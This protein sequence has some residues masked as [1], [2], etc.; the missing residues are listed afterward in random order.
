MAKNS[1]TFSVAVKLLTDQFSKGIK[2]IERQIKGLGGFIRGAFALGSITAFGKQM[3]QVSSEF[4]DAMARVH[5]VSDAIDSDFKIMEQEARRLGATTKFTATEAANALE[6]LTRNGLTAQQATNALEGTLQLAQANAI[7]LAEAATITTNVLNMFGMST[8]ETTR[9]NNVLSQVSATTAT[10]ISQLYEALVNAA[11]TAHNL[12]LSLEEVS[13]ALGAM[14]QRGV[15]GAEAGTQLRMAMTKMVDPKIVKKMNEMGIAINEEQ[16]RSEGL[17]KTIGRL[18]DAHLS[19]GQLVEI[20]SQR[21]AQ[22]MA[23]LIN[24]YTDFEIE[25]ELL[26]KKEDTAVRMFQQGLGSTKGAL[27]MLKSAYQ[28]LLIA[29]G[30][31]SRGPFNALIGYLTNIVKNCYTLGGAL[32][33][34]SSVILPAFISKII[35]AFK[36]FNA[37]VA[38]GISKAAALKV[39]MGGW[40]TAIATL[41]TFIGTNLVL[42][43]TRADREIKN[44]DTQLKNVEISN[45]HLTSSVDGLI[46][47]MGSEFDHDTLIGV[48]A[49]ACKLFPDLKREIMEAAAQADDTQSWDKLKGVLED[50]LSL[51]TAVSANNALQKYVDAYTGKV[52]Q[53]MRISANN[54]YF[55]AKLEKSIKDGLGKLG[56]RV[57]KDA[58]NTVWAALAERIIHSD[59]SNALEAVQSELRSL[60]VTAEEEVVKAFVSYFN[61][62]KDV[63][64]AR[65]R[66]KQMELNSKKEEEANAKINEIRADAAA[67]EQKIQ[68]DKLK[69]EQA[70]ASAASKKKSDADKEADIRKNLNKDL[71]DLYDDF[72][73]GDIKNMGEYMEGVAKLWKKAYEDFRE[74]TRKMGPDNPYYEGKTKSQRDVDM[75]TPILSGKGIPSVQ[76]KAQTMEEL[77]DEKETIKVE[78]KPQIDVDEYQSALA[79]FKQ[80]FSDSFT[81]TIE[82]TNNMAYAL[83][84]LERGFE[85]FGDNSATAFDKFKAASQIFESLQEVLKTTG[86]MFDLLGVKELAAAVKDRIASK[87]KRGEAKKNVLANTA[88][89]V[90]GAIK[91]VVSI[92]YVGPILAAAAAAGVIG[93]IA[94]FAPKFAKG[95]IVS[96][97]SKYGDKMLARVNSGEMILNNKQQKRLFD[98]ANGSGGLGGNVAF[99]IQGKDLV[100]VLRNNNLANSK[101]AGTL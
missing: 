78:L 70:A 18:K 21:G 79:A 71:E 76:G 61:S 28:E 30:E 69:N 35:V 53:S 72:Q 101:I 96:G 58:M 39:A 4:E 54:N 10:N 93:L 27:L 64:A 43:L 92:P 63:L 75:M 49:E 85:K 24:S 87:L 42:S 89:G 80:E 55:T 47:K 37:E 60:G 90:T 40:L 68:N 38:K 44:M 91:S 26:K 56:G 29:A 88:E 82:I 32:A 77:K 66:L 31:G 45:N 9:L 5:A 95:G 65:E 51:Q 74:L 19:L 2:N 8:K 99:K 6:N 14:A 97:G 36:T 46:H 11:P 52:Q 16:I 34:I 73:N 62:D 15:K 33:N 3:I 20:F 17:L 94:A 25:V 86:E 50:I 84:S 7:G 67:R 22:G 41:A 57:G 1:S 13:A 81:D 12:G 48:A 98:M 23:Q 59:A 83:E 100:G